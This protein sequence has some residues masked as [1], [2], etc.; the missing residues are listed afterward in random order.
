MK[1]RLAILAALVLLLSVTDAFALMYGSPV[2]S[3]KA[4]HVS[5]GFGYG[6]QSLE[7]EGTKAEIHQQVPYVQIGLGFG[8]G[9]ELY[10]RGGGADFELKNVAGSETMRESL[11]PFVGGG[12]NGRLYNGQV[13]DIALFA[14]G[15][16]YTF[17]DYEDVVLGIDYVLTDYWDASGGIA[18]ELEIDKS[19]LYFGPFYHT[20]NATIAVGGLEADIEPPNQVG[21]MVGI[22]WPLPSGWELDVE[23]QTLKDYVLGAQLSY[24]F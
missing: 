19:Y 13:L 11:M 18:F 16:Y 21:G 10:G 9:W 7:I 15:N 23:A 8:W 24:P 17:Q 22:R 2:S 5:L 4:G 14:Q 12:I 3:L 20:Y 1:L 6:A